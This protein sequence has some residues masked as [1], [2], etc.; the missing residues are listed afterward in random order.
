MSAG[1]SLDARLVDGVI[2]RG[3]LPDPVLRAAIRLLLRRRRARITAGG[4]E[5]RSERSRALIEQLAAGPVTLAV[6]AANEQHYEVPTAWFRTV[7]GPHLKYSSGWW[8]PGVDDLASAEAAML[9][10]TAERARI[11]DGQRILELGC[12]WGSLTLWLAEH[13]PGASIVGVSNSVT[14]RRHIEAEAAR[15]GLANLTVLTGDVAVLGTGGGPGG[16]DGE[17]AEVVGDGAFDRVVSVELFEH[18]RN[19]RELTRRIARWLAPG[20]ML[21]VHVFAHRSDPYVFTSG[22]RADWM[23]RTFFTGGIMPS[24]DLLAR[25][26]KDLVLDDQWAVSGRHY[27]RT[28]RAWLERID[29]NRDELLAVLAEDDARLARARLHRWRVFTIACEE[30]FAFAD[31]DEWH[32][33]HHRF[34]RPDVP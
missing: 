21:F 3:W 2:D 18:V 33:S 1:S 27:A 8:P 28:L 16:T 10:L 12:G 11:A 31:G 20:G 9:R 7:L 4:V 17:H 23:A 22:A 13:Y 34:R 5:D 29:A 6:E 25:T 14:Q 26:V 19:H 30:L 15:R 32:V 24:H